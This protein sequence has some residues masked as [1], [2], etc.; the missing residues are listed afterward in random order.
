MTAKK[1][2]LV[3]DDEKD[4]CDLFQRFFARRGHEVHV[5][6]DG[7]KAKDF[8]EENTY[9]YV[10]LDCNMPEM[11]GVELVKVIEVKNPQAKK[12][13]I[14]GYDGI[15]EN[16]ASAVKIDLFLKK[17]ISLDDIQRVMERP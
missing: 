3:V 11:S 4:C 1:K 2:I 17:P 7:K 14:S 13:M 12:I 16:F 10:F 5:A 6:Y 8:L 9:D 15:D